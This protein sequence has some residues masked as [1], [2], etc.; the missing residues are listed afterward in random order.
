M[1][2]TPVG[3]TLTITVKVDEKDASAKLDSLIK[4]IEQINE[5]SKG[6][7]FSHLKEVS[8]TLTEFANASSGLNNAAKSIENISKA[9]SGLVRNLQ[10]VGTKQL[11]DATKKLSKIGDTFSKFGAKSV[12]FSYFTNGAGGSG[13]SSNVG[14]MQLMSSLAK[15]LASDFKRAARAG[16]QLAKLPFKMLLS[17]MQG[18]V[19]KVAGMANSFGRLFSTIGRVAFMRAIR[20]GIKMVVA[21][22]REGVDHLYLWASAVGNSFKPTMDSIATSFLYLKN[23]IGAAASPILDTLAPAIEVAVNKLVDLINI[24]NQVVAT[25]TGASTWRRAIRSAADYSDNISG[26]GHDATDANDAVKELKNTLLGFDEINRLDDKKKTVSKGNKGKPATGMY[27][28]EGALSFVEQAI[29]QKALDIAQML[30]DAWSKGDFTDIGEMIGLKLGDAMMRVPWEEKIQPTV[31]KIAKSFGT[32]L[33]GMFDYNGKGGKAMWDG[34]A[35]T[36]YNALNTALLGYTT[37]F[38]TV[39]WEGIGQGFGA[40]LKKVL[41]DGINYELVADALSSF[42]NAVI[43][44]ING[45]NKEFTVADFAD[46]GQKI[47]N[48]IA[49]ALIKIEWG[50]LFTDIFGVANRI[51]AGLNSALEGFGKNWG[52]IKD[53]IIRGIKSVP[54]TEWTQLG[55]QIGALIFNVAGFVANVV[56]M[57][58]KAIKAGNWGKLWDGIKQGFDDKIKK[59]F[60]SWENAGIA[61]AKWIGDNLDIITLALAFTF[62][63]FAIGMGVKA[64]TQ[65]LLIAPLLGGKGTLGTWAQGLAITAGLMVAISDLK[66]EFD[67]GGINSTAFRDKLGRG[68]AGAIAGFVFTGGNL[69]GAALGFTVGVKLD[70]IVNALKTT[71]LDKIPLYKWLEELITGM[72]QSGSKGE[73]HG[74]SKNWK[75]NGGTGTEQDAG[76]KKGTDIVWDSPNRP[77]YAAGSSN[78]WSETVTLQPTL[79][80]SNSKDWLKILNTAWNNIVKNN[81]VARFLT[82]GVVDKGLEWWGSVKEFWSNATRGQFAS[83]FNIEGIVNSALT[84]WSNVQGYWSNA[85][86]GQAAERFNIF[87]IVNSAASWWSSVKGWW[88]SAI[89][90]QSASAFSIAGVVNAATSWWNQT[91]GY[92]N[93]ATRYSSLTATVTTELSS[94]AIINTFN[95]AQTWLN[96]HPVTAIVRTQTVTQKISGA[97]SGLVHRADGG[98]YKNGIWYPIT[99]YASGGFPSGEMF[100]AREAGPELVGTIGGNTAVMN[101]DQIVA[102]VSAG[103][104]QAVASVIGGGNTND[105]VIKIDSETIYRAV[106]K[107]ERMANGRYGTVVT[108]G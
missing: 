46:V 89:S 21:G 56:D 33:N 2:N 88:S 93:S 67:K 99:S 1:A 75:P 10:N 6:Q 63:K 35:Y 40:A 83:K 5:V 58:F 92:W 24:F 45:F 19:S 53:A 22:I 85:I 42:P 72:D 50:T 77:S 60:G 108:V 97:A 14:N 13:Q 71:V 90:G 55:T 54:A 81:K 79:D 12:S 4:K 91:C 86:R 78:A 18:V 100:I 87:G 62:G 43:K 34:I 69:A 64:L 98:V 9:T 26:L 73:F 11:G 96:N 39:R 36:V 61:L 101:N 28:Q 59:E 15:S 27:A 95:A 3:E 74:S 16:M 66:A 104:A 65:K 105:I 82:E 7:G 17:P 84:W 106:K 44:A 47:G 102:S 8:K 25:L 49:Q 107:G 52:D 70:L 57:L 68:I 94:N 31:A 51:V 30:R 103:V 23:S 80:T 32:L 38:S 48:C 29:S 37:F 41:K 76:Y 20:A